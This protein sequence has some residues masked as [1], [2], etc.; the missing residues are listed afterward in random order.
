MSLNV[1]DSPLFMELYNQMRHN[2]LRPKVIV[3]YVR[4]PYVCHNGNVR[5]TFDKELR[6]GLHSTDIFD[7]DL[8]RFERLMRT[9]LFLK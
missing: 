6:T 5:I 1:P 3:D 9:S 7:K 8:H 2:L 4:E